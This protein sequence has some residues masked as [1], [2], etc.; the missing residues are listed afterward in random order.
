[1]GGQGGHQ[2]TQRHQG[3]GGQRPA[4]GTEGH[5]GVS[6]YCCRGQSSSAPVCRIVWVPRAAGASIPCVQNKILFRFGP[7]KPRDCPNMSLLNRE[8]PK[9][10]LL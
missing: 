9:C 10:N 8:L 6:E 5:V 7:N 3:Q 1:M 2:G 4:V